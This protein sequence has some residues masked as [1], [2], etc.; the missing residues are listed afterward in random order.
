M[1]V[2]CCQ[3]SGECVWPRSLT[4]YVVTALMQFVERLTILSRVARVMTE[5][6]RVSFSESRWTSSH[7][8]QSVILFWQQIIRLL[9]SML[10]FRGLSDCLSARPRIVLK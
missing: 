4:R 3:T 7:V 10:P 6:Y 9:R 2:L 1:A 5:L 8:S